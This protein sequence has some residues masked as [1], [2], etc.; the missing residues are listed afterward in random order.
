MNRA[1]YETPDGD[2]LALIQSGYAD[3]GLDPSVIAEAEH[4]SRA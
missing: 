4:R 1:G 2:T 3:F